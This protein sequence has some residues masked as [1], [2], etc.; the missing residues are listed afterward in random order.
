MTT[1]HPAPQVQDTPLAFDPVLQAWVPLAPGAWRAAAP[2][3]P[4]MTISFRPWA[5]TDLPVFRDMLSDPEVWRFLPE[6]FPGALSDAVARDLLAVAQVTTF[7]EVRAAVLQ[8]TPIGQTRLVWDAPGNP[9]AAPVSAEFSYWLGRAHWGRGYGRR[10]AIKS[11]GLAF[12]RHPGLTALWARVHPDNRASRRI[13]G[14]AGFAATGR[15]TAD[16]WAI[17]SCPRPEGS[18]MDRI[19]ALAASPLR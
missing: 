8:G 13:L 9:G 17:L 18:A 19:A 14:E 12:A 5:G 3:R 6:P 4:V 16:G 10:I 2:E 15:S 1:D 7:H 11:T